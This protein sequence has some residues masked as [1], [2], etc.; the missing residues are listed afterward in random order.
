[1]EVGQGPNGVVA[2]KEGKK[3]RVIYVTFLE[4]RLVLL[5]GD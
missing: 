2:P 3:E 5:T 1:M 4:L